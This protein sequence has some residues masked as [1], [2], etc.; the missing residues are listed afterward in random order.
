METI[1]IDKEESSDIVLN[2]YWIEEPIDE[3]DHIRRNIFIKKCKDFYKFDVADINNAR[4]YFAYRFMVHKNYSSVKEILEDLD[5]N[6]EFSKDA[7]LALLS[8]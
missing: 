3:N 2:L 5:D 7:V 1:F 8:F 4:L 6:F